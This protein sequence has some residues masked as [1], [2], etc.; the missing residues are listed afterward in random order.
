MNIP[1]FSQILLLF[2]PILLIAGAFYDVMT[3]RLSNTYNLF[4]LIMF[5]PIAWMAGIPFN[6]ILIHLLVGSGVLLVSFGAFAAGFF[7]GGDSKFIAVIALWI[8]YD[9]LVEF[10]FL[11]GIFGGL[12]ALVV[13]IGGRFIPVEWQPAFFKAM[14]KRKVVPYGAAMAIA[15][16][17]VYQDTAIWIN[18]MS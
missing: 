1:V 13:L 14:S 15:A 4:G 8:G 12:L 18:L 9:T 17:L 5:F 3:L 10:F 6:N 11:T 7:G 16:L 2:F